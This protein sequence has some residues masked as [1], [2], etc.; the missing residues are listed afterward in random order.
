M[1]AA[2]AAVLPSIH[3]AQAQTVALNANDPKYDSPRCRAARAHEQRWANEHG[4]SRFMYQF[5]WWGIGGFIV[6]P[7][8]YDP[9]PEQAAISRDL[10]RYCVTHARRGRR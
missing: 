5:A 6:P 10:A 7:G 2:V 9:T 4:G 3:A 1:V 8:T